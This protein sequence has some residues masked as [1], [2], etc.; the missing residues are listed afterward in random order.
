MQYKVEQEL[1]KGVKN[2]NAKSGMAIVINPKKRRDS[3]DG[4]LP[5]VSIRINLTNTSLKVLSITPF[6]M[7]IRPDRS[8]NSLLT[9]AQ[10]TK[11]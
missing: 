5:D 1:E 3:G 4:E 9:A 2:A 10:L 11:I 8:L 6:T 7:F